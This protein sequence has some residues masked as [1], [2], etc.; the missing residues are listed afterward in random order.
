[1]RPQHILDFCIF[2]VI[3]TSKIA[4]YMC[5][6]ILNNFGKKFLQF[7]QF[8]Q[9]AWSRMVTENFNI[10]LAAK[11][12]VQKLLSFGVSTTTGSETQES[13]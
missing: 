11:I 3:V 6:K 2:D 9:M 1:M 10:K 7:F 12:T 5:S 8:D 4:K 13:I